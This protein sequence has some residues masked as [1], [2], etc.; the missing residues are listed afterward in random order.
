MTAQYGEQLDSDLQSDLLSIMTEKTETIHSTY[1]AGSFSRL[2]WDEQLHAA[3][4]TNPRQ[5]RWHPFI[6]KWCLNLKLISSGAYHAL[7][8][9]EF[10]KLPSE[11]TLR[12]YTHYC[13]ETLG[14]QKETL[15]QLY[16]EVKDIPESRRYVSLILDEMKIKQDLVYDKHS[17]QIVGFV[18]LGSINDELS[19]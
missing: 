4:V 9:A 2:F 3:S 8:T 7:R 12:D 16:K 15:N 5:I 14:F 13:K 10:I 11:H 18:S 1:P 6:I 19:K 17:G